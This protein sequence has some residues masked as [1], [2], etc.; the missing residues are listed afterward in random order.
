MI[1]GLYT[2]EASMRPKLSR[3]DVMANNLANITTTGYKRDRVFVEML[4]ESALG[5]AEGKGELDGVATRSYVDLSEGSLVSTGN[6]LD[7]AIQGKGLFAIDTPTGTRYTRN[8]HF[9]ISAD[10]TVVTEQGFPVQGTAG[11]I[12]IPQHESPRQGTVVVSEL[13][14]VSIDKTLIG[15]LRIVEPENPALLTKDHQS[16]FMAPSEARFLEGPG[17]FTQVRQGYLE[18][19]NVDGIEEMV[20]M[21]ELHRNYETDQKM[22]TSQDATI[23]R[24]LDVGRL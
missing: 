17:G 6:P 10:G 22:I 18:E 5:Q 1:K 2:S 14:E 23:E 15:K 11:R 4:K 12:Q 9:K 24:S 19:S 21:I 20:A 8:G 16:L 13:G 3:L 7:F